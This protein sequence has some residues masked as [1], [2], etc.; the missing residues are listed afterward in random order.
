MQIK[1]I[2]T[3]I[4]GTLLNGD[5]VLSERLLQAIA[6]L[7]HDF[8]VILASSRMPDAMRHL[9]KDMDRLGEPLICY[10]GGFVIHDAKKE[11]IDDVSISL[12]QCEAL[13]GIANGT[14]VHV[15]LYQG[16]DWFEPQFDYWAEREARNTR[17]DPTVRPLDKVLALWKSREKGA[18]KVM[19]MG[20]AEEID[21]YF[22]NA[23]RHL[24]DD[25]H[26]YR[27]KD[28]YIEIAPK[29]ISKASALSLLL[30]RKYQISMDEV[31]AFGDNYNDIEMLKAVGLGVAV[32]NAREEVKAIADRVTLSH[33]EDGVAAMIE[34]VLLG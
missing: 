32:G 31:M 20:P 34:E 12:E 2:C 15:S 33:K 24:G 9:Q 27:S 10:N 26:L 5:R 23:L 6:N 4:D 25:L 28:T 21:A 17:V 3:D 18:H 7:P 13:L 19:C 22:N 30:E 8:P 16:E 14:Q 1:A 11:I 29:K